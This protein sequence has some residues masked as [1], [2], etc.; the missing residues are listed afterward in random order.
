[1]LTAQLSKDIDTRWDACWPINSLRPLLIIDCISYLLFF[2]KLEEA[3]LIVT[4]SRPANRK[5]CYVNEYEELQWNYLQDLQPKELHHLFSKENGLASLLRSYGCTNLPY[6]M[7]LK[8]GMLISPSATLL[9]NSIELVKIIEAETQDSRGAIFEYLLH[10]QDLHGDAGLNYV[11]CETTKMLVDLAKPKCGEII[12][13]PCCGSGSLLASAASFIAGDCTKR[14]KYQFSKKIIGTDSDR[15]QLRISAMNLILHGIEKPKLF[16]IDNFKKTKYVLPAKPSVI[17][18]NLIFQG[19]ENKHTPDSSVEENERKDISLLKVI[20]KNIEDGGRAIV[21]V[22]NYILNNNLPEVKSI[23]EDIAE[24]FEIEAVIN[25]SHLPGLPAA[26]VLMLK[27]HGEARNGSVRIYEIERLYGIAA[28]GDGVTIHNVNADNA[29]EKNT[30]ELYA[31]GENE[32]SIQHPFILE[33]KACVSLQ[34]IRSN[35]YNLISNQNVKG[36][37]ESV[38][39]PVTP[40]TVMQ[41]NVSMLTRE[42]RF[43]LKSAPNNFFIS[44]LKLVAE[45]K[46]QIL[47]FA[48][49]VTAKCELVFSEFKLQLLLK[50]KK[51]FLSGT[52]IILTLPT[53]NASKSI[54]HFLA[55]TMEAFVLK[56]KNKF[57]KLSFA[58]THLDVVLASA[59]KKIR[60]AVIAAAALTIFII[61]LF[62]TN[63]SKNIRQ[64][65]ADQSHL[66]SIT[67]TNNK[68][69]N[70]NVTDLHKQRQLTPEEIKA[71]LQDTSGIIHFDELLANDSTSLID[72]ES[73]V[74]T[75]NAVEDAVKQ[76]NKLPK[77]NSVKQL[78]TKYLVADT[79]YFHSKPVENSARKSY[80]DPV[81]KN[82]LTP[83]EEVNG[84]IYVVYTNKLNITS[85]GWINKKDLKKIE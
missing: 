46:D 21:L 74:L 6:S 24:N 33:E 19:I 76:N 71:I 23:R 32:I 78:Q 31:T 5:L 52:K 81:K 1:M 49:K 82:I 55:E 53:S 83:L 75:D 30:L 66:L 25:M 12:W 51:S 3:R 72:S 29:K 59:S 65:I 84:F 2:K 43:S 26:S 57:E 16:D 50:T 54:T 63:P 38:I 44:A 62:S 37:F 7:F 61:A 85:T 58:S 10:K 79:A 34:E 17:I 39:N 11:S 60:Y 70:T 67:T 40:V 68:T 35:N 14:T 47:L 8:N 69:S 13:D 36:A 48:K 42:E 73:M 22:R 9:K 77:A 20:L 64:I 4:G 56:T 28:D 80:L 18:S 15:V 27:K 45:E 41:Q